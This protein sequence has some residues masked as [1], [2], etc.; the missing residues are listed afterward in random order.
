MKNGAIGGR[1]IPNRQQVRTLA[2]LCIYLKTARGGLKTL[3]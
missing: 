1:I 3:F 2:S